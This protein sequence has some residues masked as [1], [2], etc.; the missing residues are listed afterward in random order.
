LP[1]PSH[2]PHFQ[3]AVPGQDSHPV[4]TTSSPATNAIANITAAT[5]SPPY[6]D[7]QQNGRKAVVMSP[8][9]HSPAGS[10]SRTSSLAFDGISSFSGSVSSVLQKFKTEQNDLVQVLQLCGVL[11][12]HPLVLL[13]D[14]ILQVIKEKEECLSQLLATAKALVSKERMYSNDLN[15]IRRERQE[16]LL[17]IRSELRR[18]D[19]TTPITSR[20]RNH[21]E[22]PHRRG[23]FCF[24]LSFRFLLQA[25]LR[26]AIAIPGNLR[27]RERSSSSCVQ[28]LLVEVGAVLL[29]HHSSNFSI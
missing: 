12:T 14:A 10:G 17:E 26:R 5:S 29:Q 2:A 21:H 23:F 28:L 11:I 15:R 8:D 3:I 1:Q 13:F 22:Q 19:V 16:Q 7:G 4:F 9:L 18:E 25:P 24:G 20:L 6:S 27:Q